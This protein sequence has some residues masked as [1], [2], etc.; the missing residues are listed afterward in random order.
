MIRDLVDDLAA[1]VAVTLTL[2]VLVASI[3]VLVIALQ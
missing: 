3:T 2:A 1:F